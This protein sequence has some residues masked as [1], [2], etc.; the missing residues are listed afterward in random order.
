MNIKLLSSFASA[1]FI[2]FC[3]YGCMNN[4]SD[5]P[6]TKTD[7]TVNYGSYKTE[8]EWGKHLVVITG[9]SDCHTP[10]KMTT[11]GPLEDTSLYLSGCPANAH[12]PDVSAA[13]MG[14]F[15]A[16]TF[17]Q[18]AWVGPWGKSFA[19]NITSDSTGIGM[20]SEKQFINCLR[21]GVYKGIDNARPLM[22]PMPWQDYSKMTDAELKAI[23]TFLKTTKPIDNASPD[24]QPPV[25]SR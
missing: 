18:T 6:V 7:S 14:K 2:S 8:A 15:I 1:T 9:C 12:T 24:Y 3:F 5:K 19:A 23:F 21:K 17:D 25:A 16:A 10:K 11:H 4:A 13:P 22:P 20:W